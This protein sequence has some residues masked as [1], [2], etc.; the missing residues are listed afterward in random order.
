MKAIV[1]V[2]AA[3][4]GMQ[5]AARLA[6]RGDR[7]YLCD[8]A[9]D[10]IE[11]AVV[12]TAAIGGARADV[13]DEAQVDDF[14]KNALDALGRLDLLVNTAGIAGPTALSRAL[15]LPIGRIASGSPWTAA[16]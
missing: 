15:D 11:K 9:A 6:Q 4:I 5:V 14:M 3:G 10:G 1:T 12:E 16:F 2:A 8:I 7:V 13:A